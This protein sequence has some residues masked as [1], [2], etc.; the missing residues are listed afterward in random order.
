[1]IKPL[2]SNI[3]KGLW[4]PPL[5]T[6]VSTREHKYF[7]HC[8][9][10]RKQMYMCLYFIMPEL[11]RKYQKIN[12]TLYV[13]LSDHTCVP[14]CI[15]L[16]SLL[17]APCIDHGVSIME[18]LETFCDKCTTCWSTGHFIQSQCVSSSSERIR[19]LTWHD[20]VTHDAL[21]LMI[22]FV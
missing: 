4:S 17:L 2:I 18:V 21:R 9:Y 5:S 10:L 19:R 20:P 13:L 16:L 6:N 3:E 15:E 7:K 22:Q 12:L 1:M 14:F 8:I 11:T